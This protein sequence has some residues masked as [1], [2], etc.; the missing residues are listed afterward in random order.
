MRLLPTLLI[1]I[2]LLATQGCASTGGKDA[3]TVWT[4]AQLDRV[5]GVAAHVEGAPQIVATGAGP[6]VQFDGVKDAVFVGTHPLAGA[7][8]WT[9]EADFRPDGGAFEQ[10]WMHLAEVDPKTGAE[11]GTR[12]LFE[13]RVKDER[14]Y[15]DAFTT[16]EGYKV[17]LIEPSKTFPL[18][19]WYHVAMSYDGTTFKSY[20]DGVV[21]G[22]AP[23][24]FKPQG[25]GR[26]S[27]GTRINR[28]NY[29]KGAVYKARFTPRALPPQDF[30]PLPAGL[31]LPA[32]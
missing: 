4:F 7:T 12:F 5:G 21:Q 1:G 23:L 18:G 20:V 10:R 30:L 8:T 14:W 28:V 27:V 3:D 32:K 24:A 15:L 29:F 13:I 9:I 31:N 25:A 16:G 19:R 11:T 22:E 26:S 6:A 2:V 17:T